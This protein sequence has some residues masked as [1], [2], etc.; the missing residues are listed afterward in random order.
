MKSDKPDKSAKSSLK[1]AVKAVTKS[2]RAGGEAVTSRLKKTETSSASDPKATAAKSKAK[3]APPIPPVEEEPPIIAKPKPASRSKAVSAKKN[4]SAKAT[5]PAI[6][7]ILLEG[8]RPASPAPGG[9]GQRYALGPTP[10][11]EHQ[12]GAETTELPEAYGTK[13]LILTARDPHWLYARW[14]LTREQQNQYN[15]PFHGPPSR[16]ADFF[17]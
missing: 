5:A 16:A 9:P 8:D 10:P 1:K 17:E 14:D 15:A 13:R 4:V 3:V 6:P 7:D 11:P 12:G 2:I